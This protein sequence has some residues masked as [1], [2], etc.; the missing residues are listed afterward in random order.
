MVV[1]A[2][3]GA[4]VLLTSAGPA[5]AFN[6]PRT[7]PET[8]DGIYVFVDQLNIAPMTVAQKQFAARHYVGTQKQ[9][10][11]RIDE[12]RVYN[13]DFIHLQYRLGT[14]E[15]GH[16]ANYIHNDTWSNDWA[17]INAHEDWF[18]HHWDTNPDPRVYQLYAGWLK[19]YCMDVSGQVNGA[20]YGWK[21][22]WVDTVIADCIASHADGVFADSSNLPYA[23]PSDQWASPMGAPPHQVFIPHLEAWYDY[24]YQQFDAADMYFIPNIGGL[25]TTL[26]TTTGYYT[27]VHG[28]MVEGFAETKYGFTDW[29]MQAN[30]M[31]KLI[32]NGK[33]WIAQN[34]VGGY[35]DM[36]GRGWLISNFLLLKHNRSFVN[37]LGAGSQLHWWPEY[38][39]DIGPPASAHLPSDVNNF[40]DWP[41]GLYIRQ[42]TRGL[43]LVNPSDQP[44]THNFTGPLAKL[45]ITPY[46]GGRILYNGQI[47][48]P[49]GLTYTVLPGS[50][51]LQDWSGAVVQLTV[52]GD[53]N[54]DYL[55]GIADLGILADHYG[56]TS[57]AS[58][59][60]GDFNG[61][62]AVGIADLGVLADNYGQSAGGMGSSVVP[63]PSGLALLGL[64]AGVALRGR[65]R[66]AGRL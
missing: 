34:G 50:I 47:E 48:R 42:Y 23:V 1:A 37:I 43:V 51:T 2:A 28:A 3:L 24:V 46:G 35:A 57:G 39:I 54:L 6:P 60:E 63:E 16:S 62:G 29:R 61:D 58:W 25:C 4:A 10:S 13:P 27:D 52:P 36:K 26:D 64:A 31:L 8:W 19:E 15:S 44:R 32:R 22:Y 9:V 11:R 14:R 41:S 20:A 65:R 49:T 53:A 45:L 38:D 5:G 18:I 7:F 59:T 17:N 21:E 55:T 12:I 30:R 33:I 56:Q 40:R 66:R